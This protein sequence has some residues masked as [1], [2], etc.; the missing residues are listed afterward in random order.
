MERIATPADE[1]ATR[2]VERSVVGRRL[3]AAGEASG[4]RVDRLRDALAAGD[5]GEAGDTTDD[6]AP[7]LPR[8]TGLPRGPLDVPAMR[9]DAGAAAAQT[10]ASEPDDVTPADW[11]A[12]AA[13]TMNAAGPADAP[14][15]AGGTAEDGGAEDGEDR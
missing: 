4:Y 9:D 8:A 2:P 3:R 6:R 13:G 12:D 14:G 1:R 11:A 5:T 10:P 7:R 15:T